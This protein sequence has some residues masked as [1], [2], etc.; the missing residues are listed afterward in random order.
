MNYI[1]NFAARTRKILQYSRD[2]AA[3]ANATVNSVN[4]FMKNCIQNFVK[5]KEN[6]NV[7]IYWVK[8]KIP[9]AIE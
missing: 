7:L 3:G 8:Q 1:P 5:N 2:A 4:I 9:C 6:W